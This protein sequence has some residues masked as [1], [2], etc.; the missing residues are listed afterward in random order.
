MPLVCER[1]TGAA[2]PPSLQPAALTG[3]LQQQAVIISWSICLEV[4]EW[5][6]DTLPTSW[7][8]GVSKSQLDSSSP[9]TRSA[10]SLPSAF[11][12]SAA[13]AQQTRQADSKGQSWLIPLSSAGPRSRTSGTL[14]SAP[15]PPWYP[16][17][18]LSS[19]CPKWLWGWY[20]SSPPEPGF[21]WGQ[22]R[23]GSVIWGARQWAQIMYLAPRAR[24]FE[25]LLPHKELYWIHQDMECITGRCGASRAWV[26]V[27]LTFCWGFP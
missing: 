11:S 7:N 12:Q 4:C 16:L 22:V 19:C 15:S 25:S 10:Q 1:L 3:R 20:T 14:E 18:A 17:F 6:D 24:P 8:Q 26:R 13:S 9:S 27:W 2:S 21:T 5:L 23:V